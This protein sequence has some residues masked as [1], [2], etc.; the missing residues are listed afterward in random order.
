MFNLQSPTTSIAENFVSPTSASSY[1]SGPAGEKVT[2]LVTADAETLKTVD[3]TGAR[4]AAFIRERIFTKVRHDTLFGPFASA[5]L[6]RLKLQISDE[7]QPRFSIYRTEIGEYAL[8]EALNDDQLFEL[9]RNS[10]DDKGTIKLLVSHSHAPVHEPPPPPE[11]N[12][13]SPTVNTIP[14]PVL[15]Q[16]SLYPLRPRRP[17]SK[18]RRGSTSSASERMPQD[19]AAA[20]YEASVSDDLDQADRET[21]ETRRSTIRPPPHQQHS[22]PL[23]QLPPRPRSPT[24]Y[25]RSQSPS[26]VMSPERIRSAGTESHSATRAERGHGTALPTPPYQTTS[27]ESARFNDET[28]ASASRHNRTASDAIVDRD[29]DRNPSVLDPQSE[30]ERQRRVN[31]EKE[32]EERSRRKE[33]T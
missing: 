10:G 16:H 9:Y 26:Q 17:L 31:Q 33:G 18:S 7:D 6:I 11:A 23:P 25:G 30:S 20:G 32:R 21:R 3:I 14:P 19:V 13:V 22:V 15:P 12:L 28:S 5:H 24:A 27:P 1:R 2:L 4:D 8:G 29:R